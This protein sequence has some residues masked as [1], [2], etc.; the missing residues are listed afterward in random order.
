M[1]V[2]KSIWATISVP[3]PIPTYDTDILED[4][5]NR[6]ASRQPQYQERLRLDFLIQIWDLSK[7]Y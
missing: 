6:R 5:W 3:C 7:K 2:V 4:D 1:S